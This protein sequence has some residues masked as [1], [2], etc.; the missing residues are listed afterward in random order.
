VKRLYWPILVILL[1]GCA[2][3]RAITIIPRPSR[4]SGTTIRPFDAGEQ[5]TYVIRYRG[6]AAGI[7]CLKTEELAASAMPAGR[8]VLQLVSTARSLPLFAMF[9]RV[10]DRSESW[11][12][13]D[14]LRPLRFE[15]RLVDGDFRRDTRLVFDQETG[16][17]SDGG[18]VRL[19]GTDVQDPLSAL[20]Y[21][22]TRELVPGRDA[23]I[24]IWS[25]GRSWPARVRVGARETVSVKA[26]DFECLKV[27]PEMGFAGLF[28]PA[29]VT[30]WLSDD[31]RR[32]PVRLV[33][34]AAGGEM[35]AE[36]AEAIVIE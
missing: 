29:P 19:A 6:L 4:P 34:R 8:S 28:R 35:T 15:Q 26:G 33:I 7:G 3:G 24:R 30:V 11:F 16:T 23:W 5:L 27:E 1:A 13:L 25:G 31:A 10:D 14:R 18:A 36:L 9:H 22:R 12:D 20:Y 32:L 17:V 2:S 21:F